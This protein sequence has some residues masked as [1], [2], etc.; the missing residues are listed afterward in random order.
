M[1]VFTEAFMKGTRSSIHFQNMQLY[2][3]GIAANSA[4]LLYRGEVHGHLG[5]TRVIQCRFNV[6]VPRARVPE[7]ASTRRGRSER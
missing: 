7:K 2:A 6:S 1:G 3:F 4:A 5:S